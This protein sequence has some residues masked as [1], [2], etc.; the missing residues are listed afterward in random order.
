MAQYSTPQAGKCDFRYTPSDKLADSEPF[1]C[2]TPITYSRTAQLGP[3]RHPFP[4][5]IRAQTGHPPIHPLHIPLAT[6][7][8]HCCRPCCRHRTERPSCPALGP[9]HIQI[10][11]QRHQC[12]M[13]LWPPRPCSC[14]LVAAGDP[15][16]P[17]QVQTPYE[18]EPDLKFGSIGFRFRFAKN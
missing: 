3:R 5:H 12:R 8:Y 9:P 10:L 13:G 4:L 16:S 11:Q 14:R 1:R 17:V 7:R 15:S 18:P 2:S 6:R